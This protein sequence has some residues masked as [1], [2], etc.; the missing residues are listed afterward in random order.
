MLEQAD[1]YSGGL[2]MKK[3][4]VAILAFAVAASFNIASHAALKATPTNAAVLL[5]GKSVS[6]AAYN[7]N[8]YNFFKLRDIA[9]TLSGTR[10]QFSI[11]WD[12]GRSAISLASGKPYE[13]AG[14]EM[15]SKASQTKQAVPSDAVVH[16]D[17]KKISLEA[18]NIDGY[19]FYKLRDLGSALNFG[20]GW[21][22]AQRIITI[23][24]SKDYEAQYSVTTNFTI[25]KQSVPDVGIGDKTS[26]GD[27]RVTDFAVMPDNSIL[28]LNNQ[29]GKVFRFAD[30]T[31]MKTYDYGLPEQDIFPY[32][33]ACDKEGNIFLLDGKHSIL[34]KIDTEG[35]IAYSQFKEF[36]L[37]AVSRFAASGEIAAITA[38]DSE[39]N[40]TTYIVDISKETAVI[41]SS[42]LGQAVSD[43]VFSPYHIIDPGDE[44][45]RQ[46]GHSL[47][48]KIYGLSGELMS[49]IKKTLEDFIF[50]ATC[51][52]KSDDNYLVKLVL[53]GEGMDDKPYEI[54]TLMDGYG[55]IMRSYEIPKGD[56]MMNSFNER[57]Y[58]FFR[59]DSEL[60][61]RDVLSELNEK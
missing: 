61:V 47:G 11:G 19:T 38:Y 6:F 36:P 50:G 26:E 22:S 41:N 35:K 5:N 52:G 54:L 32:K 31:L 49:D 27:Y 9:F 45:G 14:G 40:V 4:F 55:K 48:I 18:Y 60:S 2:K 1:N 58:I 34:M 59:T 8:D 28:I 30:G 17:G 57:L 51:F 7:I 15:G 24:A 12:A 20:I 16:L 43:F 39:A 21:D 29:T 37:T 56:N 42:V 25:S 10:K 53:C 23:D 33:L 13:P 3:L 44:T 46:I